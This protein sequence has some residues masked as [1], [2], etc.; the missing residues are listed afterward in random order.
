MSVLVTETADKIPPSLLNKGEVLVQV[1]GASKRFCKDLKRS[2]FYGV[3]DI[4]NDIQGVGLDKNTDL[5][6]REFWANRNITF[7]LRRGEC[8]GLIGHN[9]AGKTT[10]LKMLNGLIKPDGGRIEIKGRV[11]A[12]IALGAGFNP[13]LTGRENVYVAGSVYG[14][15]KKEIDEKYDEIVEFAEMQAFMESPV[16]N[17][18]SGMSVRL[19]FAVA[20]AF[21]PDV[22]LIDEVLAVG[23]VG[24]RTRCYNRINRLKGSSA[25]IFVSHNVGH[26]GRLC[27]QCVLLNRGVIDFHG[28]TPEAINR[29][30]SQSSDH[31]SQN[32]VLTEGTVLKSVRLNGKEF[33]SSLEV[34]GDQPLCLEVEACFERVV[35][36][37]EFAVTFLTEGMEPVATV[38]NRYQQVSLKVNSDSCLLRVQI[39]WPGLGSGRKAVTLAIVDSS[40]NTTLAWA[41]PY[42]YLNVENQIPV[43]QPA[44][45][46][47]KFESR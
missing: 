25:I 35:R 20:T 18:S 29:Y 22:L 46:C 33:S 45:L 17:Y 11:G 8:L 21:K 24:F 23:D 19:G 28:A 31:D 26:I 9:G 13:I 1:Q 37:V 44:F 12:L 32:I 38:N 7:E 27:D 47:G 6:T 14:L 43:P 34:S 41:H 30:N 2:L 40:E 39:P 15:S 42:G 10:L 3:Q 5:R 4:W 16:Q 36:E